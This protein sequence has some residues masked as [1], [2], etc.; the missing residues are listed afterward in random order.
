MNQTLEWGRVG[1]GAVSP[2]SNT[3]YCSNALFENHHVELKTGHMDGQGSYSSLD[4][5]LVL[6][7]A[8]HPL[9]SLREL[10]HV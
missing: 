1:W 6:E 5:S 3:L 9:Y 8:S 2:L 4:I 10:A 7:Q